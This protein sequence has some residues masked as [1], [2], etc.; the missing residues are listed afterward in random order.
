MTHDISTIMT[1]PCSLHCNCN[2][3]TC[4]VCNIY[5][6]WSSVGKESEGKTVAG[7][8][9]YICIYKAFLALVLSSRLVVTFTI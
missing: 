3:V 8:Y 1:S 4:N 2:N 6:M 5:R 7:H 9:I